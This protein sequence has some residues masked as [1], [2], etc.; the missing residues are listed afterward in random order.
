[1]ANPTTTTAGTILSAA[2]LDT[3]IVTLGKALT[4]ATQDVQILGVEIAKHAKANSNDVTMFGRLVNTL[5]ATGYN[6]AMVRAWI[7][8]FTPCRFKQA[9]EGSD[10]TVESKKGAEWNIG[11]METTMHQ[12]FKKQTQSEAWNE[13]VKLDKAFP[14]WRRL[15]R[16]RAMR[17]RTNYAACNPC[18]K[19]KQALKHQAPRLV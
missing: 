15:S 4:G 14:L 9:S 17:L 2:Q 5:V 16:T 12:S 3:K 7:V 8:N 10:W 11:A 1:M 13:D 6:D 18:H 19:L